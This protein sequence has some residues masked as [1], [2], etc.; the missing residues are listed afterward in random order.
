MKVEGLQWSIPPGMLSWKV[1][2]QSNWS[3]MFGMSLTDTWRRKEWLLDTSQDG[4]YERKG[5]LFKWRTSY[6]QT[7]TLL[8]KPRL[9]RLQKDN[10]LF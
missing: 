8:F 4:C 6:Q 9:L 5:L 2:H 7:D 1:R 10:V 3:P